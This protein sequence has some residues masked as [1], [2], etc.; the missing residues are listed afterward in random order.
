[1]VKLYYCKAK[2]VN[3]K[4][5]MMNNKVNEQIKIENSWQGPW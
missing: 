5:I 2:E 1:M 3:K 4:E